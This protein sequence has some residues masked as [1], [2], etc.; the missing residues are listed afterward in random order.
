MKIKST[1]E[2]NLC[3]DKTPQNNPLLR[4]IPCSFGETY[5][6]QLAKTPLNTGFLLESRYY[7]KE[8]YKA[9]KKHMRKTVA[10][11]AKYENK[12]FD[13]INVYY[14]YT[15]NKGINKRLSEEIRNLSKKIQSFF[16][17]YKEKEKEMFDS[18]DPRSI[19]ITRFYN[20]KLHDVRNFYQQIKRLQ[21]QETKTY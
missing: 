6:E 17:A 18:K 16:Y 3:F 14:K 12:I 5:S 15:F 7:D 21:M 13:K 9:K 10:K 19:K 4:K 20:K 11:I 1:E 2:T 8:R